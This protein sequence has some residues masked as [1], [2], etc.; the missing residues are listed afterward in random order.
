LGKGRTSPPG[1]S[2][3]GKKRNLRLNYVEKREGEKTGA[4]EKLKKEQSNAGGGYRRKK[5]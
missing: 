2:E 4:G 5:K 3:G 1:I